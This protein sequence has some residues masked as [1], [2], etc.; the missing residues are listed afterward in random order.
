VRRQRMAWMIGASL[1]GAVEGPLVSLVVGHWQPDRV[2]VSISSVLLLGIALLHVEYAAAVMHWR[3]P[4]ARVR[5]AALIVLGSVLFA[6]PDTLDLPTI[7]DL[8]WRTGLE[9]YLVYCVPFPFAA[10]LIVSTVRRWVPS[11]VPTLTCAALAGGLTLAWPWLHE[12]LQNQTAAVM[13]REMRVP[14]PM[15]YTVA[16]PARSRPAAISWTTPPSWRPTR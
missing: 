5:V 12:S 9:R 14:G 6:L 3:R 11:L 15:L 10:W 2:T 16:Y 8:W 1:F 4:E 13:R 7:G